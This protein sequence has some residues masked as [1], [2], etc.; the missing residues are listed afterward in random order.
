MRLEQHVG[1]KA[2]AGRQT[3]LVSATLSDKVP[4]PPLQALLLLRACALQY[5]QRGLSATIRQAR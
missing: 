2:D 5:C 3:V 4:Q 1:R